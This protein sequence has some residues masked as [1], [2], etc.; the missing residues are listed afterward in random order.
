MFRFTQNF[1]RHSQASH[2][3]TRRRRSFNASLEAVEDRT[4]MSTLSAISWKSGGVQHSEVFAI[5]YNNSVSM[6]KDCGGFVSESGYLTAI[7]AGLDAQ[8]NPEVFGIGGNNAVWVNDNGS[9]LG[10]SGRLRHGDQRG[11]R[12]HGLRHRRQQRRVHQPRRD[13]L[14][15]T[16]RRLLG[17]QRRP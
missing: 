10:Q 16:G 1:G 7:S 4:L 11:G 15:R 17:D 3:R 13:R 6:S 12:Q 2:A 14:G 5:G 8:G 9:R